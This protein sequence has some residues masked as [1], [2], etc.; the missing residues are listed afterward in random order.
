[1]TCNGAFN[2]NCL[3]CVGGKYLTALNTC[4]DWNLKCYTCV[5]SSANCVLS[6]NISNNHRNNSPPSC[7]CI[8]TACEVN[9][10]ACP[11]GTSPCGSC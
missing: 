7:P 5:N 1:M 11:L 4:V 8:S 3:T 6:T 9:L 2:N 10:A